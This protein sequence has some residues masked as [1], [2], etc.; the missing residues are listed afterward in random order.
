VAR[1]NAGDLPG[2]AGDSF[3]LDFSCFILCIKAK[4]EVGIG[5]KP[6]TGVNDKQ[7]N[8]RFMYAYNPMKMACWY[9]DDRK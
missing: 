3:C 2:L 8:N 4:K 9:C 6:R 7:Q 5:A 1:Q